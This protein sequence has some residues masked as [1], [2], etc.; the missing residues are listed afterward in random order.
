MSK[1]EIGKLRPTQLLHYHGP[2]AIVDL[3]EDSVMISAADEWAI[4][5][6]NRFHE[7]RL[8]RM[9]NIDFIKLISEEEDR[10]KVG[11]RPFPKWRIC[12]SCGMMDS[13]ASKE[14][15][16]CKKN[17]DK[18][19]KLYPSRF[20][21]VCEKGH[22]SDFP[23]IEWAHKGKKCSKEKPIL[24]YKSKGAA[25]SLSDIVVTCVKCGER[26]TL[27]QIM[28]AE[29]IERYITHCTG[30]RPWLNDK[31]KCSEKMKTSLRG[32]SN[33]YTPVITSVLSIPLTA[34]QN[35]EL[36]Y[37]VDSKRDVITNLLEIPGFD[38]NAKRTLICQA[39]GRSETEF[40]R[41]INFFKNE[42]VVTFDSIRK[43]EWS[44]LIIGDI[45]DEDETGFVSKKMSLHEE[46]QQYFKSI[47][48]VDRL[49]EVRV[50]NGFSRL[51]YPD[52]FFEEA[53]DGLPIMKD[54]QNWLPGVLVHGEGIFFEFNPK[55]I[56]KWQTNSFVKNELGKIIKKYN[57]MREELGYHQREL[58][59]KDILIHTFSHMLI[60]EFAAHSGYSTTSLRERLYCGPDM[61]GVLIYTASSDSEGSLGGLIE[62]SKP[63]KL[64]PIFLRAIEQFEHCSSDPHCSDGD[65][66]LQT[67]INGAACHACSYVSETSCEWNNHLLDRRT[68]TQLLDFEE[69]AFFKY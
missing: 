29:E 54:R 48:R 41:I 17:E 22:I 13:F 39:L 60:K 46:L 38:E 64:F 6:E 4:P 57:F 62:L 9:L 50:L 21:T 1:K 24:K 42:E 7:P 3:L 58:S 10:I 66:E 31:E 15:F 25:G 27:S 40:E 69:V 14:C 52:P 19:V 49:R 18:N 44:T 8:E 33:I 59:P 53:I 12:P 2:G 67:S 36:M 35:D 63:E 56:N 61:M 28:K 37:I 45:N 5:R 47:V 34:S 55:A 16:Y 65:F 68:I 26:N 11:A 32:A 43:Q 51:Q 20:I 23:W 30:E